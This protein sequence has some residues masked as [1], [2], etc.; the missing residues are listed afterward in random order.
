MKKNSKIES[1]FKPQSNLNLTLNSSHQH[2]VS[3]YHISNEMQ[4]APYSKRNLTFWTDIEKTL[5]MILKAHKIIAKRGVGEG[6]F[7]LSKPK[8]LM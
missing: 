5:C 4:E 7:T 3:C 6:W 1:K 2:P 8:R